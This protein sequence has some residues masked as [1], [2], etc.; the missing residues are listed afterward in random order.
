MV[1]ITKAQLIEKL[2]DYPDHWVFTIDVSDPNLDLT[3]YLN[4][5]DVYCFD[6]G[7]IGLIVE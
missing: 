7:E 1:K 2:K 6:E 3:T 4:V 5:V